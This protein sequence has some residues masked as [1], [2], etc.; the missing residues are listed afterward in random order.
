[1]RSLS[2]HN[3]AIC[4]SKFDKTYSKEYN[5]FVP[6]EVFHYDK[7]YRYLQG[8]LNRLRSPYGKIKTMVRI[9]S[10]VYF[11][12][13]LKPGD[14]ML[15][16]GCNVGD[17]GHYI[18]YG[19]VKTKG[20]DI[21][22]EALNYGQKMYGYEISNVK[23]AAVAESLPF[24]DAAFDHV[25]S[26]DIFEHLQ[27]EQQ[28]INAFKEASRVCRGSKMLHK[29]TVLEDPNIHL[30]PS[31][32]L[33]WPTD[34]WRKFFESQGWEITKPTTRFHIL[35]TKNGLERHSMLGYFFMERPVTS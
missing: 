16:I 25:L 8:S 31:H 20:I 32:R 10:D 28:A 29:V 22:L 9:F 26:W 14:R 6:A 11:P 27:S 3:D 34:E 4:K 30:D 18:G 23:L 2:E 7:T 15:D 12:L 21:N 24:A 13:G 17:L 19:G 33:K 5:K 1:M 35:P